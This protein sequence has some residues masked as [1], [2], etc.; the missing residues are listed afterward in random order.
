MDTSKIEKMVTEGLE[1][2]KWLGLSGNLFSLTSW[3]NL[4]WVILKDMGCDSVFRVLDGKNGEE[5]YLLED[6]GKATHT[7]VEY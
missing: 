2:G 3:V 6:W 5:I 7:L 1:E 4:I